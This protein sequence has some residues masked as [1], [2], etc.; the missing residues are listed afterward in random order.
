MLLQLRVVVA[1]IRNQ[2]PALEHDL[3]FFE[4]MHK[5]LQG[6]EVETLNC[7]PKLTPLASLSISRNAV[8][9]AKGLYWILSWSEYL[10]P[11]AVPKTVDVAA[12]E[13]CRVEDS[14]RLR[15]FH[16]TF[17]IHFPRCCR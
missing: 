15:Q 3:T 13:S 4:I 9:E 8:S 6:T 10:L 1:A 5:V 14:P 11:L 2:R 7:F 17:L 12:F 16:D